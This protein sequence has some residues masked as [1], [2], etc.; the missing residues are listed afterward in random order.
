[1]GRYYFYWNVLR[2][3]F[4]VVIRLVACGVLAHVETKLFEMT[5]VIQS[6]ALIL[7]V[8]VVGI[9]IYLRVVILMIRK[10]DVLQS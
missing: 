8:Q 2:I 5:R 10:V 6:S 3:L 7:I 4:L 1:M 9:L